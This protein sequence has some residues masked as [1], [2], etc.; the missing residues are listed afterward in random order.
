[1]GRALRVAV[2]RTLFAQ[3]RLNSLRTW[4]TEET[5]KP[6]QHS[7]RTPVAH[8]TQAHQVRQEEVRVQK[9]HGT[10]GKGSQ[11]EY[12]APSPKQVDYLASAS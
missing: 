2:G 12:A 4:D 11:R 5:S 8:P 1:M 9:A 3:A 7:T 10:T 6:L